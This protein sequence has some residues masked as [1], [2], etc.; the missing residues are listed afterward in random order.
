MKSM[1]NKYLFKNK[2]TVF[3]DPPVICAIPLVI[4]AIQRQLDACIAYNRKEM[5]EYILTK[6][7]KILPCNSLPV[8]CDECQKIVVCNKEPIRLYGQCQF[9]KRTFCERCIEIVTKTEDPYFYLIDCERC[10]EIFCTGCRPVIDGCD[11][12]CCTTNEEE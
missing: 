3:M 11:S 12:F 1:C 10:D 7:V 4:C 9:C 6:Y 5:L 8:I 2:T